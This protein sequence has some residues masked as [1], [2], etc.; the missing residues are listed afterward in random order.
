METPKQPVSFSEV[1]GRAPLRLFQ[2]FTFI[3][4]MIVL[5]ADGVDAQLLGVVTP[6]ILKDY[7]VDRTS[8][9]FAV[10][11]AL[12]GFGVGSWSGG[13]L[14]DRI[15][16]RWSLTLAAVVFSLGTV[17]AS[18]S[19][20]VMEMAV[21]RF[22][23]GLGFG[24]AYAIAIALTGEWLP[25]RWRSVAVTTISVGTPLGGSIVGALAPTVVGLWGWRGAFMCFGAVTF[26]LCV[27]LIIVV[28][29]DSPAFLLARG[30]LAE[31]KQAAR[32]VVD[33]DL[34]LVPERHMTDTATGSIGVLDRSNLRLNIGVGLAFT[35]ATLVA[36]GILN[37]AT[38]LLTSHGFAFDQASYTVFVAG[39]TSIAGSIAV[40]LLIQRY[41][42]KKTMILVGATLLVNLVVLAALIEST[43]SAPDANQRIL[44]MALVGLLAAIF[45][46]GVGG[47]YAMLTHGYPPSC[48]SAGI[49]FGIFMGRVG[50]YI[51][52]TFGGALLDMGKG[53]VIPY[54]GALSI[55]AVLLMVA[56]LIN[57][58]HVPPAARKA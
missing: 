19:N 40:G 12:F 42:S 16:R 32:R 8:F 35:S 10:G 37:W 17:A 11:A 58:R 1:M 31:A 44:I 47:M 28:L 51:S 6:L 57:D 22:I 52:S 5:V 55:G 53:S 26:V 9:G 23:G 13:M 34:N 3:V 39:I 15:G 36:Y 18:M 30:R 4:C 24:A 2:I 41:G 29:R 46:S 33:E 48:R 14:G 25:D 43:G 49:G 54:F 50:A 45:S 21:W 27:T 38:T 7:G 20:T 56:M